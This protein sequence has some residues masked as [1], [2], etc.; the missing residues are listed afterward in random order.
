MPLQVVARKN[1]P[2]NWTPLQAPFTF[3]VQ[4]FLPLQ[5]DFQKIKNFVKK[6]HIISRGA[7]SGG[8]LAR[9]FFYFYFAPHHNTTR[10]PVTLHD[11]NLLV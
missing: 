9:I 4:F 2:A 1:I 11:R 7:C 6:F 10:S 5:I 3:E 8:R